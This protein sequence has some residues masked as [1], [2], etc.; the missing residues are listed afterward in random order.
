MVQIGLGRELGA[1]LSVPSLR[2]PKGS[3]PHLCD[4]PSFGRNG[5]WELLKVGE[6]VPGR[7]SQELCRQ[8]SGKDDGVWTP[9]SGLEG[10]QM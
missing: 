10:L 7:V 5:R 2:D 3:G 4:L 9:P 8:G 1:A 6:V